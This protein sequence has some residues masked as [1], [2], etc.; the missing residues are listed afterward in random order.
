MSA[1]AH[2]RDR[3]LIRLPRKRAYWRRGLGPFLA[4]RLLLIPVSILVV[5][6]ISFFLIAFIPSSTAMAIAGE[7]ATPERIAQITA[8]LGL[9]K[10]MW[11]QFIDYLV[12]LAHF[13][14]GT[15]FY[16]GLPTA[17][18]L[19]TRI[20]ASLELALPAFLLSIIIGITLGT[21][22][23]FFPGK[24]P[25]KVERVWSTVLHAT[26]EFLLG[27]LGIYVVFFLLGW[28]P[29]PTGR[30]AITDTPPPTVTGFYTIDSLLIGDLDTFGHAF[31]RLILPVVVLALAGSVAFA[32]MTRAG[33][34]ESLH[35]NFIEFARSAG[36]PRHQIVRYA[37]LD[38]RTPILTYV[39]MGVG[40][41]IGGA[42]II[43]TLFS[44]PGYGAWGIGGMSSL[45]APVIQT[46]VLVSGLLALL[47]YV[48][49]DIVSVIFDPRISIEPNGSV[50][51][52][53]KRLRVLSRPTP[54]GAAA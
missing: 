31:Q 8:Q 17:Q 34:A 43:E 4:K 11:Q 30:L 35:S 38:V 19:A 20:P 18:E 49:L 32:R 10:P 22:G 2:P 23:A 40:S 24:L 36:L 51:S 27:V 29:A 28:V 13:D 41:L 9:D 14:L 50:P 44:W 47:S 37:L 7:D 15:S 39:A 5:V 52:M 54:K 3:V 16:T 42:A 33:L 21:A 46:F 48:V 25:D 12:R 6:M 1:I 53:R 26:P 45:D